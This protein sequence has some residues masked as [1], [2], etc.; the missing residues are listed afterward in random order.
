MSC[1]MYDGAACLHINNIQVLAH[2][3]KAQVSKESRV[4]PLNKSNRCC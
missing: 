3:H 1:R 2:F 4:P